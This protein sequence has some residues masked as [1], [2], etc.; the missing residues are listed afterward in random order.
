[1]KVSWDNECSVLGHEGSTSSSKI[2][3]GGSRDLK[4]RPVTGRSLKWTNDDDDDDDDVWWWCS[5]Q[6]FINIQTPEK[7]DKH[8]PGP[9]EQSGCY[10]MS[11][12]LKRFI[13]EKKDFK[14]FQAAGF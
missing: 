14:D 9:T 13:E 1:M 8:S 6:D 5:N 3:A 2:S 7:T 10:V 12:A 11:K 4:R